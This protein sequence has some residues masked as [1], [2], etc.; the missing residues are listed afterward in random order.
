MQLTCLK[1]KCKNSAQVKMKNTLLFLPTKRILSFLL[2][3]IKRTLFFLAAPLAYEIL[4]L[5]LGME[6]EPLA[7]EALRVL[8]TGPPGK[9]QKGH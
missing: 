6:P 3:T 8:T 5:Q 2:L 7:V 1:F 4:V 9:S